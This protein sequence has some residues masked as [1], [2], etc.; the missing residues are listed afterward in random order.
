VVLNPRQLGLSQRSQN[1]KTLTVTDFP[2]AQGGLRGDPR[3]LA[4]WINHLGLDPTSH[5]PPCPLAKGEIG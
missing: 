2:L 4:D 5:D 1:F 3:S